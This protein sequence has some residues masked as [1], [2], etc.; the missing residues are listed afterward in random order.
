MRLITFGV[1]ADTDSP[2]WSPG[3]VGAEIVALLTTQ[4]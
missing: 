2:L 4:V 3:I 1:G